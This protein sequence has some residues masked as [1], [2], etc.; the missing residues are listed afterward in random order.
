MKQL[1][2]IVAKKKVDK[3][4]WKQQIYKF[5]SF[6]AA[7]V[8]WLLLKPEGAAVVEIGGKLTWS[9]LNIE[10]VAIVAIV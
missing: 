8:V 3:S 1:R 10:I 6:K 9:P 2:Q 7:P 4:G 5:F